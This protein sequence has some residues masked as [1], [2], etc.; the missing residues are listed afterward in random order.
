MIS[1]PEPPPQLPAN[2]LGPKPAP[3]ETVP[4]VGSGK[5]SG[6]PLPQVSTGAASS[7][8]SLWGPSV[9]W[10]ASVIASVPGR[11]GLPP[12]VPLLSPQPHSASAIVHIH[13]PRRAANGRL[14]G[15]I[16]PPL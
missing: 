4:D 5:T 13:W 2:M 6:P 8:E 1:A 14:D 9:I 12:V 3:P 15:L 7:M 10:G 11:W 16:R